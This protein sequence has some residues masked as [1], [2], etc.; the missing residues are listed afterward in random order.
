MLNKHKIYVCIGQYQSKL[1]KFQFLLKLLLENVIKYFLREAGCTLLFWAGE[2]PRLLFLP[3]SC[4]LA[5][6]PPGT[7]LNGYH[8]LQSSALKSK[9]MWHIMVWFFFFCEGLMLINL[10]ISNWFFLAVILI[11][12]ITCLFCNY[13]SFWFVLLLQVPIFGK[14]KLNPLPR[15]FIRWSWV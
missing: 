10:L 7:S 5:S 14:W 8:S 12:S 3:F 2:S 15:S 1:E 11:S 13:F 9:I 6:T 4:I